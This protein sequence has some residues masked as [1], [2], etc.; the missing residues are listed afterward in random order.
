MKF[1]AV[2]MWKLLSLRGNHPEDEN[3]DSEYIKSTRHED[4]RQ[5]RDVVAE[6]EAER[7]TTLRRSA[8]KIG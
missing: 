8:A 3:N 4:S 6:I 7:A 5:W 2:N 1:S